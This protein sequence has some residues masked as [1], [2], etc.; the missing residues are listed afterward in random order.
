MT[1]VFRRMTAH[2]LCAF[3]LNLWTQT[4]MVVLKLDSA[5]VF[6]LLFLCELG[7]SSGVEQ[8]AIIYSLEPYLRGS[9]RSPSPCWSKT[10]LYVFFLPFTFSWLSSAD[11]MPWVSGEG[12]GGLYVFSW[13]AD[14]FR[15]ST[16]LFTRS[17][18]SNQQ[19]HREEGPAS[20][21]EKESSN[22]CSRIGAGVR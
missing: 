1:C 4:Q 12:W 9:V 13:K 5:L 21:E 2:A 15:A 6:T 7:V 3:L 20:P 11:W 14:S 19:Q 18:T 22:F 17:E 8:S 10:W 16:C